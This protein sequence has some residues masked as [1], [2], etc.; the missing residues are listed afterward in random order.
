M[1]DS[2]QRDDDVARSQWPARPEL[3]REIV[4]SSV[5]L[6]TILDARGRITYVSEAVRDLIGYEPE[7]VVGRDC[8][9]FVHPDSIELAI[10]AFLETVSRPDADS[11]WG[12]SPIVF[13]YLHKDGRRV[14]VEVG[15]N[16]QVDNPVIQGVILRT[17]AVPNHA[18][19]DDFLEALAMG[20]PLDKAFG[21]L[22]AALQHEVTTGHAA[23]GFDWLG[24]GAGFAGAATTDLPA[25]LAGIGPDVDD[26]DPWSVAVRTGE[27]VIH[28]T[29]DG[30]RPYL[31]GPAD[32][33]GLRACFAYP[34]R[35]A[36][37]EGRRSTDAASADGCVILWRS[38][39]GPPWVSHGVS[40]A[41]TIHLAGIA[42]ERRRN[43]RLLV[44]AAERDALTGIPNR[45]FFFR[46]LETLAE[47]TNAGRRAAV[48][49]LDLDAFK[50]IN[51][52]H[53]HI[54][55]DHALVEIA[56]RITATLRPGDIAARL[57]GDEFAVL[58]TNFTEDTEVHQIAR[59]LIDAIEAP[60]AVGDHAFAV[61]ASVGIA[62]ASPG[63]APDALVA[64][65]DAALL[66]AK[67]AGKGRWYAAR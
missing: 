58:C 25:P 4:E 32:A 38:V 35:K 50:P 67:D 27:P 9:D 36:P 44:Q 65:A 33:L 26:D 59:R 48:L 11:A 21:P 7:E 43:E 47:A 17:R 6:T 46:R 49:Y 56:S 52:R 14:P 8:L 31:R 16:P 40:V 23:I 61:G 28:A 60:M 13:D 2:S 15:S 30:L 12:G 63:S 64:A 5:Y 37:S 66:A 39:E 53:G 41:R 29:L 34:I 54:A 24:A 57:G 55:G 18:L 51:D 20:A 3:Y 19:L 1:T 45:L 62:F 22:A 42:F 10:N